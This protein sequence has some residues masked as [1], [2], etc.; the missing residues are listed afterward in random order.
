M[1]PPVL[2]YDQITSFDSDS[3]ILSGSSLN[4]SVDEVMISVVSQIAHIDWSVWEIE[5]GGRETHPQK[6]INKALLG[7]Q[8]QPLFLMER[9]VF[10][11]AK[12]W[13]PENADS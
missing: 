9:S 13:K 10:Q 1:A 4:S 7:T 3:T 8:G 2:I 6:I 12:R 5:M 11:L